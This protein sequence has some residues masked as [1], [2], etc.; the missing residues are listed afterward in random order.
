MRIPNVDDLK[1]KITAGKG[2]ANPSLYYVQLPARNLSGEQKQS[3]EYFVRNVTLPS[4]N[5]LTVERNIGVDQTKV[6]YGYTNGTVSMTFRVLN[7][8]LTRQYIEDWQNTMVQRYEENVE[9]HVAIAYPKTYMRD[10]KISQLDR[11]ISFAGLNA[12]KGIGVGPINVN[13]SLD[14]DIRQ[15]GREVYRWVL[16]D[17]YPI[18]F[19]QEQ[20]SDDR[21]G[22]TSE[23]TVEFAYKYFTGTEVNGSRTSG[24]D[25][26]VGVSTDAAQKAGK[27][28][29]DTFDKLG[30]KVSDLIF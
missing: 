10:I 21:K 11:G 25:A 6:P 23:I 5:M 12:N 9:G 20:L 1:A 3:I 15:S 24:I 18:S 14:V 29:N 26:N 22:V 13:V 27:L 7:D 4:R 28:V 19:T 30:K 17:A 2:Y 16:K 8:Q